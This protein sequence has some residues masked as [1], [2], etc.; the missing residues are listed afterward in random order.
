M[1]HWLTDTGLRWLLAASHFLRENRKLSSVAN[2]F[3]SPVSVKQFFTQLLAD[4]IY[5]IKGF[6]L[7]FLDNSYLES[8]GFPETELNILSK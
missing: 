1:R 7:N 3:S 8:Y 2:F 4:L 6:V 5:S